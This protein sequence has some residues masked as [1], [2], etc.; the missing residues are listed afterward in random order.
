M[1]EHPIPFSG[2]MVRAILAGMKTQTRRV[3]KPQPPMLCEYKI[4]GA[5]SH[6]L[7]FG[8]KNVCVPPTARSSDHRLPCPYGAPGDRLWLKENWKFCGWS[9][10]GEPQIEYAADGEKLWRTISEE[11]VDRVNEIWEDL[12]TLENRAIDGISADRRWRSSQFMFRWAS[13]ITLEVVSVRVERLQEISE[14]DARAEGWP[15]VHDVGGGS[16]ASAWFRALWDSINGTKHPWASNPWVWAV[17]FKRVE[18]AKA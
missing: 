11:S 14:E 4:N 8:P 17:E 2:P 15:Y 5:Q 6:A 16:L 12:S 3:V 13:R 9:E 7:C 18:E 10:D 1:K